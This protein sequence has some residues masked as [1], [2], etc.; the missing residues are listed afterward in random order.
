MWSLAHVSMT[1]ESTP[2]AVLL[3]SFAENMECLRLPAKGVKEG[4]IETHQK[5]HNNFFVMNI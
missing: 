4:V 1:Q 3:T 5:L 2:K